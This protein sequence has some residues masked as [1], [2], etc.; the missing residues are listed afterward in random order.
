M[1]TGLVIVGVVVLLGLGGLASGRNTGSGA[2]SGAEKTTALRAEAGGMATVGVSLSMERE[3]TEGHPLTLTYTGASYVKPHVRI[4]L[5]PGEY[6]TVTDRLG[7]QATTYG[8]MVGERW[9]T[10]VDGDTAVLTVH[11]KLTHLVV[12]KVARGFTP[13]ERDAQRTVEQSR[14]D[15]AITAMRQAGAET[16]CGTGASADAACFKG[17]HPVA[18]QNSRAVALLLIDGMQLC[19][20]F[21]VG[22][23]NRMLTAHHCLSETSTVRDTEIWFN[24][25][26]AV[27]G[28]GTTTKP[29]KVSGDEVLATDAT[30]DYTLFSVRNFPLVRPFGYLSL[31]VR[32][33]GPGEQLY[34]PQHRSGDPTVIA[35]GSGRAQGGS[36]EIASA[37]ANGYAKGTDTSYYCDTS[38]GSSG[39]PVISWDSNK[40]VALH[41]FGGC[42]DSGVRIDRI[43]PKI[44]SL[45]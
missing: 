38:G 25:E 18:Y 27:C 6:L 16:A 15:A 30:L 12:D 21:R 10:S 13:D 8:A 34:I 36:C 35:T 1:R 37:A 5:L 20:A 32:D 39:S 33:P 23:N 41:H 45:L 4:L 11:G 28:G 44:R 43:Y 42:P 19:T 40:V 2:L 31:D 7:K 29:V 9:L 14:R 3:V 17:S 22:P 26:C 24:D